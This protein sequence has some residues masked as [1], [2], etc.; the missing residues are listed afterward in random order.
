MSKVIL[1]NYSVCTQCYYDFARYD[2]QYN[3]LGLHYCYFCQR[4]YLT[5]KIVPFE[6]QVFV[7]GEYFLYVTNTNHLLHFF[8]VAQGQEPEGGF[9]RDQDVPEHIREHLEF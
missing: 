5:C 7:D 9:V 8:T 6:I 2:F 1:A 3:V 4:R